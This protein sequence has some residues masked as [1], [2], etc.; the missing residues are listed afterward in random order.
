MQY[1]QN[2]RHSTSHVG[3]PHTS[4]GRRWPLL[5]F[6]ASTLHQVYLVFLLRIPTLYSSRVA[7]VFEDAY[8]D[9]RDDNGRLNLK[10]IRLDQQATSASPKFLPLPGDWNTTTA[11]PAFA[12]FQSTWEGFVDSL[13]R[14][15]KMLNAVSAFLLSLVL[16]SL[17]NWFG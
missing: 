9:A 12:K 13:L 3:K 4:T 17:C 6:L 5:H 10:V 16:Q 7:H 2:K 8:F 11:S 1:R 15:W 14:E